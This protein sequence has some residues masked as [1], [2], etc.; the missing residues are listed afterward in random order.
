[1]T[2]LDKLR[3]DHPEWDAYK[4]KDAYYNMCPDVLHCTSEDFV[5]RYFVGHEVK[6]RPLSESEKDRICH[7][8]WNTEIPEGKETEE[9]RTIY[10]HIGPFTPPNN[11]EDIADKADLFTREHILPAAEIRKAI[12]RYEKENEKM[13]ACEETL[14]TTCIHREVCSKKESYIA[15]VNAV[16]YLKVYFDDSSVQYLRNMTWIRPIR[17]ECDY[18]SAPALT[19]RS[20]D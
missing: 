13:N 18:Y 2:Y 5:C 3:E 6:N 16:N 7:E 10:A 14:C 11:L 20:V 9:K 15:A 19:V 4:I 8:C 12:E 1:M 17:L